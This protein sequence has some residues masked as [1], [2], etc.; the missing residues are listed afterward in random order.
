VVVDGAVVSAEGDREQ[1]GRDLDDVDRRIWDDDSTVITNIGELVTNDPGGRDLLGHIADAALVVE[2]S[3]SPGWV[4]PST[5]R[6]PTSR[7]TRAAGRCS[8]ASSTPL[9]P[10]L[11]R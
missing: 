4:P 11:R 8:P 6:P 7:S 1:L 2:G 3:T 10:G 5:R 9:P